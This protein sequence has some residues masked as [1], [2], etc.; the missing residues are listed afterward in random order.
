MSRNDSLLYTGA[1]SNRV[2]GQDVRSA[3][4]QAKRTRLMPVADEILSTLD[5]E[6]E[7]TQLELLK[8]VNVSTDKKLLKEM[9]A[10]LNL[11]DKSM[12]NL[13]AT[14]NNI[15]R[16]SKPEQYAIDKSLKGLGPTND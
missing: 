10:A 4:K 3:E 5:K 14:F 16:L 8:L 7:R 2:V 13:R 15:L 6:R 11:Y 1:A 9:I 12:L